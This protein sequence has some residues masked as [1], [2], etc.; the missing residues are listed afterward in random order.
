VPGVCLAAWAAENGEQIEQQL[1]ASGAILFRGFDLEGIDAF[2][3]AARAILGPLYDGYGDLPRAG[4]SSSIYASTPYPPDEPILFHNESS[5]LQR[6]PLRIAFFAVQVAEEG[7]ETPILDCREVCRLLDPDVLATFRE[8]GLVYV[9]NF[10]PGVD[11]SWQQFFQTDCRDE[12]ERACRADAMECEWYGE[13]RLRIRTWRPA[14]TAH[15]EDREELFFNQVQ[16]HHVA[17]L[18]PAVRTAMHNLLGP[19]ELPRTVCYGDGSPIPDDVMQHLSQV[20]WDACVQFPWEPGDLLALDNMRMAHAR[21]PFKGPRKV[22]VAMAR[23]TGT[24]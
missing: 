7:G 6:W 8:K 22:A 4:A 2:E 23:I 18:N 15:P 1:R 21:L 19:D 24:G 3:E 9:R 5:H 10:I 17:C 16:L 12:V 13:D 20:Y 11:V 14:V